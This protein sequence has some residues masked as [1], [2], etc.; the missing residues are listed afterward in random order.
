MCD[1][2]KSSR[3]AQNKR[4]SDSFDP[5]SL[6]PPHQW[7]KKK[8]HL[9]CTGKDNT[10]PWF[11]IKNIAWIYNKLFLFALD[12]WSVIFLSKYADTA[13]AYINCPCPIVPQIFPS[14]PHCWCLIPNLTK[15]HI[16]H[17]TCSLHNTFLPV[18]GDAGGFFCTYRYIY[19]Y[20]HAL[21]LQ[22]GET[23]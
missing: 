1:V 14:T 13:R 22:T 15:T 6:F 7:P 3:F 17:P 23:M 10:R 5:R 8:I 20:V 16:L 2:F 21:Y 9:N 19:L 12:W 11:S 18:G 4:I